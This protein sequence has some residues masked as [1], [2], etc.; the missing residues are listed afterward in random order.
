MNGAF[1]LSGASHL[2]PIIGDPVAQVKSPAGVTQSLHENGRDVICV[3]MHVAAA[4]FAAVIKALQATH[5]V[6]GFI[7]TVPHKFAAFD[8]CATVTPRSQLLRAVNIVRRN[9]DGSWH[10]DMLDG[11]GFAANLQRARCMLPV[12]RALLA[13]AGGA[14]SAI[15][16]ALLEAGVGHLAIHDADPVRRDTLIERLAPQFAGRVGSGSSDPAGFAVIA[17]ATPMGM[18]VGDPLPLDVTRL[19]A[20]MFVADVITQPEVTPLLAAARAAGCR[21]QTGVDMFHAVL[22][23]MTQFLLT[24]PQELQ[25][26]RC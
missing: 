16:L 1:A 26:A 23:L 13:G 25:G 6:D 18:R 19:D 14:G 3:P 7:A 2:L 11:A 10:G 21:T 22:A 15:A 8:Q 4:Q 17:N 24:A 20:S 12:A 5:N 9:A